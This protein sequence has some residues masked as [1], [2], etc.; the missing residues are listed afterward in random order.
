MC[1]SSSRSRLDAIAGRSPTPKGEWDHAAVLGTQKQRADR[2]SQ[3]RGARCLRVGASRYSSECGQSKSCGNAGRAGECRYD[4]SPEIFFGDRKPIRDP[5]IAGKSGD[6]LGHKR[7]PPTIRTKAASDYE[8]NP[9][10]PRERP[11]HSDFDDAPWVF[12]DVSGSCHSAT[13]CRETL[14]TFR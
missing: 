12:A 14:L 9:K 6:E 4:A 10:Y 3:D 2:S 1:F 8:A 7:F 5:N 11:R 13:C